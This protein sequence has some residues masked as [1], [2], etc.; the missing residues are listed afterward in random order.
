MLPSNH[1]V[2][3]LRASTNAAESLILDRG[4]AMYVL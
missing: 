1:T 2:Q 4:S 3:D